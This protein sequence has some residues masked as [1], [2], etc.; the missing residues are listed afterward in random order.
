MGHQQEH[1]IALGGLGCRGLRLRDDITDL[2]ALRPIGIGGPSAKFSKRRRLL[3]LR[4]RGG[5]Q[6]AEP[7]ARK[8]EMP[9]R[10][11]HSHML[12]LVEI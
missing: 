2:A 5:R 9:Y 7:H 6:Q 3:T 8:D 11:Q 1:R 10:P 12:D 4:Q